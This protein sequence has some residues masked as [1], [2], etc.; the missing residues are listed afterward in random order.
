[1]FCHQCF[2]F[3]LMSIKCTNIYFRFLRRTLQ[4]SRT[5]VFGW[6]IKAELVI[7]TCTRNTVTPPSMG[8]WNRC[9]LRWLLVTELGFHAFKLSRLQLSQLSSAREKAPNNS[10]I[11]KS[12]SRWSARRLGHLP[13]SWRP[14]TRHQG[15][16]CL[17]NLVIW[18]SSLKEKFR[19]LIPGS[20]W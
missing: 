8:L 2:L 20:F 5:M 9:T 7:T 13:E 16:T 12:S 11:P 1:M 17:C 10:T 14:H 4:Q 15:P 3:L 6:G 19:R 18:R